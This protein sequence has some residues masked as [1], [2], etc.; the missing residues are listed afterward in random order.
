MNPNHQGDKSMPFDALT[1]SLQLAPALKTPV[2]RVAQFDGDL[3]RQIRRAANSV[4]LN[5]AEGRR[6]AGRDRLHLWRVAAGSADE[7]VAA[8]KAAVGWDH[9]DDDAIAEPLALLDRILAMLHKLTNG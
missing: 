9:L 5:V 4:A 7:V 2:A 1:V 8:L 6:R 3:A